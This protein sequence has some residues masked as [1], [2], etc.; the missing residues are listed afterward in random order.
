MGLPALTL[1]SLD[2]TDRIEAAFRE[3]ELPLRVVLTRHDV[4]ARGQTT[5]LKLG[6]DL[7]TRTGLFL[8]WQDVREARSDPDK[9]HL[10]DEAARL[11]GD[12][13]VVVF[14][15]A[16]NEDFLRLWTHLL[17]TV[18][19]GARALWVVGPEDF[20]WPASMDYRGADLME[21]LAGVELA[22]ESEPT[23]A[24]GEEYQNPFPWTK[25]DTGG[26]VYIGG[27]VYT[28]GGDFIGGSKYLSPTRGEPATAGGLL[29]PK[30]PLETVIGPITAEVALPEM[31]TLRIDTAA[32]DRVYV[33]RE[34]EL[35]VAI[36]QFSSPVLEEADL[37]R[38]SSG[39][40][41][42][43]WPKKLPSIKLRVHIS[44]PACEI[45]GDA[46]RTFRLH[47]GQDSPVCY[48]QMTPR[49]TGRISIVVTVYQED[50]WLGNARL[51]T[52]AYEKVTGETQILITSHELAARGYLPV[53]IRLFK[54][55]GEEKAYP[56][57]LSIPNGPSFEGTLHLPAEKLQTLNIDVE[58]YG[59]TL[60]EVFFAKEALE[61][62][63][64]ET[65][66]FFQGKTCR[67][68]VR[69][70][71]DPAEL[72]PI[73]WERLYHPVSG[74]W[75]PLS[76]T[77]DTLLSRYVPARSWE[78][79]LPLEVRPLRMLLVLA[80]PKDLAD[81]NLDPI[82]KE[83]RD[84][85]RTLFTGQPDLHVDCLESETAAPPT[86]EQLKQALMA[87][88]HMVHVVCH[89]ATS[90]SKGTTLF[91]EK[92]DGLTARVTTAKLVEAFRALTQQPHFCFLATCESATYE[93]SGAFL[94]LGPALVAKGGV[95]AVVAMA[96]RVGRETAREFADAFYERLLTHGTVDLAVQEARQQVRE[97]WDWSVPVLFSRLPDNQLLAVPPAP[98]QPKS[99]LMGVGQPQIQ[100]L[101]NRLPDNQLPALSSEPLQAKSPTGE[102]ELSQMQEVMDATTKSW[103]HPAAKGVISVA[104]SQDG[105]RILAGTVDK[106]VL[107]LDQKGT[108]CWVRETSNQPW[109]VALSADG[110][111]AVVGT[112]STRPWDMRGRG[113][114]GF[115]KN[116][117]PQWTHDLNASVWGLALSADDRTLVVG[118]DGHQAI[119]FNE[120]GQR[121]WQQDV[122]GIGWQGWVWTAAVSAGGETVVIGTANKQVLILDRGGNL[123]GE[124]RA[125]AD[126]FTVGISADGQTITAGSGDQQVYLLDRT[127]TLL[128]QERLEDKIWAVALSAEGQQV[129]VGAGEKEAHLRAFDRSGQPR[130]KRY[131]KGGVGGLALSDEPKRI[132]VGTRQGHIYIFD[133][134]GEILHQAKARKI[135][136]DVGI[137]GN[138]RV[139]AAA[140]E[141]GNL[142]TFLLPEY[143]IKGK[144][145]APAPVSY[146]SQI[147]Q[148]I[149]DGN[150]VGDHSTSQVNK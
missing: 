106:R 141:D 50:E 62:A 120:A 3:E 1:L 52:E 69:L 104:V 118:T 41:Q 34:F 54:A 60:G 87:G 68:R 139:A 24:P 125:E 108:V 94:P 8:S 115:D 113:I 110:Q 91:L 80:S 133:N 40:L 38:M 137:S 136:R 28:G 39:E 10:L 123:L 128:W 75:Q 85:W 99:P 47:A 37:P 100:R 97:H 74:E 18:L 11:T 2:P 23:T 59:K 77:V 33:D 51:Y 150:V 20:D 32:P 12:A 16:P 19:K 53:D 63:Y 146:V 81:Y 6:G 4:P 65:Q 144:G 132:I 147:I 129:I 101:I 124:H 121:L 66:A 116:G 89:G 29:I 140:S 79:P 61:D 78:Q 76:A 14:A 42:V 135:I 71:I 86:I 15:P 30:S 58:G 107:C 127:G 25:I 64:Q 17:S 102:A 9:S 134:E 96:E 145:K 45:H 43:S 109:R 48:F 49:E 73:R 90:A 98:L 119:L 105:Q 88:Y 55:S 149:G 143:S 122:K 72:A 131:I 112:G 126:V 46:S 27:N 95:P 82:S 21:I 35:A 26:G 92:E 148:I 22:P 117:N 5:L 142:Y 31:K 67:P 36:R 57:E 84:M 111:L 93:E 56:I 114:T 7:P 130:W 138:G 13:L 70:R 103:V 83:E 44:A